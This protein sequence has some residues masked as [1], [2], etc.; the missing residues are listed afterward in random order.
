WRAP[1]E[2]P[3]TEFP[4]RLVANNPATRLH[5]QLDH[6]ATSQAGKVA[7]REAVRMHPDDAAARGLEP[8]R[9]VVL[10]SRRGSCLGGLLVSDAVRR[11]VVQMSTGAWF[12]PVAG[13]AAGVT[14]GHGNVNV[15]TRDI[16]SSR[17][18]QACT[19]QHATVEVSAFVGIPPRVTVFDQPVSEA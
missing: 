6:G 7:G 16:G 19:G 1:E 13:A 10:R 17:L 14:C 2:V 5:S 3:D 12:D 4:L 15:L 8:G 11:G 18:A 9:V